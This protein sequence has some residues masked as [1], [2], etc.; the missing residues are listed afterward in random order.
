MD[1]HETEKRT[2]KSSSEKDSGQRG[3][4]ESA[5]DLGGL[6][7]AAQEICFR[8]A[9]DGEKL[10]DTEVHVVGD[11]LTGAQE[12]FQEAE[13]DSDHPGSNAFKEQLRNNY[14]QAPMAKTQRW[15]NTTSWNSSSVMVGMT[16]GRD[17]DSLSPQQING[18]VARDTIANQALM[19][20][21]PLPSP[22]STGPTRNQTASR[23][24]AYAVVPPTQ[25][26][27]ASPEFIPATSS[28]CSHDTWA[29][30]DTESGIAVANLVPDD[31]IPQNLPRAEEMKR[32][33]STRARTPF[34]KKRTYLACM[35]LIFLVVIAVTVVASRL[36]NASKNATKH[37]ASVVPT[38]TPITDMYPQQE[39][40]ILLLL[41]N[42]T[43]EAIRRPDSPQAMAFSW[44]MGDPN[45]T[46]YAPWQITQRLALATLYHATKGDSWT[47]N[48]NWL[49]YQHHECE[50]HSSTNGVEALKALHTGFA[51]PSEAV[52][53][54]VEELL[55]NGRACLGQAMHDWGDPTNGS[56]TSLRL[57]QNNL[58]GSLPEELYLITTLESILLFSNP[59][60]STISSNIEN[61]KDLEVL[62]IPV[63]GLSGSIPTEVGVLSNMH[64]IELFAGY[65][66]GEIPTEIGLLDS[67]ERLVLDNNNMT[68][69]VPT[70]LAELQSLHTMYLDT[71]NLSGTLPTEL[72]LLSNLYDL[73]I[74]NTGISGT[75][76]IEYFNLPQ[77]GKLRLGKNLLTG[78]IA[79]EIGISQSL[80]Y[81]DLWD[82]LLT[83]PIPTETGL[84]QKLRFWD[85][86]I[87]QM[88][89]T[90]PSEFGALEHNLTWLFVADNNL[91]GRVPTE[92]GRCTHMERLWLHDNDL[93]GDLFLDITQHMKN[94]SDLSVTS[95]SFSG[96]IPS[97]VG[98]LTNL[99]HF[100][101]GSNSFDGEIPSELGNLINMRWLDLT[102]NI[103][104]GTLPQEILNLTLAGS[105]EFLHLAG[106]P[107]LA[108]TIP[109]MV[110]EPPNK[111]YV[112]VLFDC[113]EILC[114]C[115]CSCNST[116]ATPVA[117]LTI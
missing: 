6:P 42:Y 29:F 67:L 17:M 28:N 49:S 3:A 60:T 108:G 48:T 37:I 8:P 100:E 54:T 34:N 82:N 65:L 97:Q 23:P 26:T 15:E 77:L 50:W 18:I 94:L 35:V 13:V 45:L 106:N 92:L 99:I 1:F 57:F 109:S 62:Y 11:N 81:I 59:L 66:T 101:A 87:N 58:Q 61:L 31:E 5:D 113:T 107:L 52:C 105:L 79:T 117:N 53:G 40:S 46:L 14:G 24:G 12:H 69:T 44:L 112:E 19:D 98:I 30:E 93:Y 36:K 47:N 86:E 25:I 102:D 78:V 2:K 68:S 41:P 80:W 51:V 96:S 55:I 32:T 116:T 104:Q 16:D 64:T 74:H 84:L 21:Q 111:A 27:P 110:C 91:H 38:E 9:F 20:V 63:S 7:V 90:L 115:H 10:D 103:I 95:N 71:N 33:V 39:D 4:R 89:G 73:Q 70:E 83:G 114:G 76:P 85:T 75:I 72:G 43:V 88:T 56:I 22:Q